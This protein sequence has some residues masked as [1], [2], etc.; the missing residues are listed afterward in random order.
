MSEVPSRSSLGGRKPL[1]SLDD[2]YTDKLDF[3]SR[4]GADHGKLIAEIILVLQMFVRERCDGETV[5]P[6]VLEEA[7]NRLA[8]LF[9][10]HA[11]AIAREVAGERREQS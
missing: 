8:G 11:D 1:R 4:S 10:D 6:K 9:K 2:D 3:L 5:D 7:W